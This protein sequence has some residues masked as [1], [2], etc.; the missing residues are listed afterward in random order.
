MTEKKIVEQTDNS[1]MLYELLCDELPGLSA[2]QQLLMLKISVLTG[3]EIPS[4][5]FYF[6]LERATT[7][8]KNPVALFLG[9]IR[10]ECPGIFDKMNATYVKGGIPNGEIFGGQDEINS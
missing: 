3:P 8:G 9:I 2:E 1:R 7:K 5:V 10:D 6:A 4:D